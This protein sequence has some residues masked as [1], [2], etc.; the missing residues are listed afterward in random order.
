MILT[1]LTIF[2]FAGCQSE[3]PSKEGQETMQ[4][5]DQYEWEYT[6]GMAWPVNGISPEIVMSP[7]MQISA[8]TEMGEITVRAGD[9]FKR[10]YTWDGAT[11]SV[12]LWARKNRWYGSL[13]IYYPGPGQHWK[14]NHGITR[15][16]L[17]EGVLWFKTLD[18][19]FTWIKRARSSGMDC[20]YTSNGLVIAWGKVLPRKQLDVEVWQFM[21]GG[22]KPQS[23]PGSQNELISVTMP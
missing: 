20:V 19:A 23:L 21:I 2:V 22:K 17:E 11:R 6:N 14:S 12:T 5:I 10:F 9:G 18:D 3:P 1:I 13:G 7:G 16:V 4:S 15:G 8:H